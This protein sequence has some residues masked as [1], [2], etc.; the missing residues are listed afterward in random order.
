MSVDDKIL[1]SD[2]SSS[3]PLTST[4]NSFPYHTSKCGSILYSSPSNSPADIFKYLRHNDFEAFRRSLDVY[5]NEIIRMKNE[6]GQVRDISKKNTRI[7]G[8]FLDSIACLSYSC[9]S[10]PMDAFD[11]DA[12]M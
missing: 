7:Y 12:G 6:Y 1:S 10:I 5:H 8:I 3:F 2:I 4:S 11:D 9:L